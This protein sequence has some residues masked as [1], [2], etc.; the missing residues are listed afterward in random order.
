MG[1]HDGGISIIRFEI[2]NRQPIGAQNGL[3][4]KG[5]AFDV[6]DIGIDGAEYFAG[7]I[8]QG[9]GAPDRWCRVN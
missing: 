5:A 2:S 3:V 8:D 7:C 9:A 1:L 4:V 6:D